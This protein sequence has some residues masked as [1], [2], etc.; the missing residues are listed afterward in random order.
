[1]HVTAGYFLRQHRQSAVAQQQQ[2]V[3]GKRW[4]K[5]RSSEC[6]CTL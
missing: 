5:W 2:T 3:V 4:H 6:M 1:V